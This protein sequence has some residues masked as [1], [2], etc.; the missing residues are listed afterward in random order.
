MI[1]TINLVRMS[2]AFVQW[3][4]LA[5]LLPVSPLYLAISGLIWSAVG[6]SLTWGLWH[7]LAWAPPLTG[8][9]EFIYA[10]YYWLDRLLVANPNSRSNISFAVI[11]TVFLLSLS[12]W[13][14][15]RPRA[16]AFFGATHDK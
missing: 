4:F 13:V 7:G 5:G 1:A 6:F 9:A 16:K 15:L 11:A 3:R 14:L 12:L 8:L 10:L 2:Q